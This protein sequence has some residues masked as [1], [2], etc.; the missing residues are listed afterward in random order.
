LVPH[1][2]NPLVIA[3]QLRCAGVL[4]AIRVSRVGFPHRYF[5]AHFVERYG[6]LARGKLQQRFQRFHHINKK[7]ASV[8]PSFEMCEALV[9]LLVPQVAQA[10]EEAGVQETMVV[11]NRSQPGYV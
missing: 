1:D 3:D 5:H 4:E 9:E 2:F 8:A 11:K 6:L 10:M 7:N